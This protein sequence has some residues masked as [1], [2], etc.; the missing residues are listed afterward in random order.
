MQ[1]FLDALDSKAFICRE[2]AKHNISSTELALEP[3]YTSNL[4][5][6]TRVLR[7]DHLKTKLIY[8]GICSNFKQALRYY[9]I[10]SSKVISVFSKAIPT[11][12]VE[13]YLFL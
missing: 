2:M 10:F 8:R 3:Y 7:S 11:I 9:Y 13:Q 6:Q 12:A 4:G 1:D 5:F